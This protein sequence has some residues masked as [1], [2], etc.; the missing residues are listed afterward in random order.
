MPFGIKREHQAKTVLCRVW[1]I[2]WFETKRRSCS[3]IVRAQLE[4][5]SQHGKSWRNVLISVRYICSERWLA[6]EF[7]RRT[8]GP[9]SFGTSD[10]QRSSLPRCKY[11]RRRRQF[12]YSRLPA[13]ALLRRIVLIATSVHCQRASWLCDRL[14]SKCEPNPLRACHAKRAT[15]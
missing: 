5:A 11:G 6:A 15:I 4:P 10:N 14:P 9:F 3:W 7:L 12:S 1:A 8:S 2:L 13:W